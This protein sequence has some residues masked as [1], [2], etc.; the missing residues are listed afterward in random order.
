MDLPLNPLIERFVRKAKI[1]RLN[2]SIEG[3]LP[4]D[5]DESIFKIKLMIEHQL[6]RYLPSRISHL[7]DIFCS[8]CH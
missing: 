8:P 7:R 2:P 4:K 6:K 3:L 1:L 5:F